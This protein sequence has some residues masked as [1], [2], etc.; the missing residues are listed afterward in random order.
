MAGAEGMSSTPHNAI[1]AASAD[2]ILMA[3]RAKLPA[4]AVEEVKAIEKEIGTI[5]DSS[6]MVPV[7]VRMAKAWQQHKQLP[8]AAYFYG[9][10]AK[11]ENSEKSL[12]FAGQFFLDLLHEVSSQ[13]MHMWAAQEAIDCFQRALKVNPDNDT[14]KMALAASYIEGTGETMQGVQ[15]LLGI[16]R[17]KPDNVPAN[18]MLGR[19]AIQSGQFD[20]AVQRF[21]TVLK[22]EPENTEALYFL[23]EAYKGKGNKQKAIELFEKCKKIV[24]NPEFSRDIDQYINS[25]K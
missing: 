2:S 4:H 3:S 7:F 25:F 20:K 10:S 5:R 14:T 16:T 24:N 8:A 13:E 17:E 15:M 11:L 9:K 6:G 22:S 1:K 19:L 21:E 12:N 18:L 23:A